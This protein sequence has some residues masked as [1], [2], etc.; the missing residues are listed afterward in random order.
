MKAELKNL[1]G[2]NQ[3]DIDAEFI[4]QLI[5]TRHFWADMDTD[6][7]QAINYIEGLLDMYYTLSQACTTATTDKARIL[8]EE[9][10]KPGT[11][12]NAQ[13]RILLAASTG[14]YK[15]DNPERP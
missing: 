11:M 3:Q 13:A 15:N 6:A 9:L 4:N 5:G 12:N 10:E 7:R 14:E 8:S 1:V 2:L